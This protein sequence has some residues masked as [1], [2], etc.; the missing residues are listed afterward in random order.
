M[1]ASRPDNSSASDGRWSLRTRLIILLLVAT[2]G[3]W[4]L[5]SYSVYRETEIESQELFDDSLKETAY[6]LLTV[7]E[8]EMAEH[9][10]NYTS[11][12]IDA[13][14]V[15]GT[16]YLRFQI[17]NDAGQLV[18]RS[19]DAPEQPMAG[20]DSLGYA[21]ANNGSDALRTYA[22][23]NADRRL[24]IQIGEPLSHR[25]EI[26]QRT[27]RRLAVFAAFFL[28]LTAL[29]IWWIIAR[30]FEPIRWTSEAVA[31]RT[32]RHLDDVELGNVPREIAPL[33]IALNRLLGRIRETLEHERSFTANAA[34]ELRTPLAAIRAHAQVLQ[35]ARNAEE[36]GEAAQDII[37]GV[38]RSRRLVDQLL[39][40]ARL[41]KAQVDVSP[42][43][44]DL[45]L[46]VQQQV[47]EHR[48]F[49]E[50]QQI[51]LTAGTQPAV[52]QGHA[53]H[54]NI[55]LRNLID[56]AL[57]YTPADGVVQV[58]CGVSDGVSYLA[59]R[60]S[61]VGIPEAERELIFKRFYRI[62]RLGDSQS[63][64]SGLGLSIVQRLVDQ[65]GAQISIEDGLNG[66]GV[67][68]V[69]RFAGTAAQ[70]S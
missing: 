5:A 52:V 58:S 30:S 44:V 2:S 31:R 49:A 37:A 43:Q 13:A 1:N 35:G 47:S 26:T 60:D 3:L 40:L 61:G 55:L 17:W 66:A 25:R 15:P 68:F 11:Q 46:L 34:H 20:A 19:Q 69:V 63:Y 8:H 16:H 38:D 4:A 22:A 27:V 12:M 7:V 28:P 53:D 59:V 21:W 54:L 10:I 56:N 62:N 24:Q 41:D 18:Y 57:R 6:L 51:V 67:G 23:W 32:G 39:A 42:Q 70:Q 45:A 65:Y 14:G 36:A 50:R 29:L 64:G 9:G 48:A 33:I